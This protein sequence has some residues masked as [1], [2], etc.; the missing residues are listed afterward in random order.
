MDV[1]CMTLRN[2]TEHPETITLG[3]NELIGTDP[4]NIK[5]KKEILFSGNWKR[6]IVPEKW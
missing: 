4:K 2:N 1:P 5:P 6:G 3:T